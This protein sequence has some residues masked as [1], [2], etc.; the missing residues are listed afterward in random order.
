MVF[1]VVHFRMQEVVVG[2]DSDATVSNR[3]VY[4]VV[5]SVIKWRK[6][7]SGVPVPRN[8]MN[9]PIIWRGY[10][11]THMM[12]TL[13]GDKERKLR[14]RCPINHI[15]TKYPDSILCHCIAD[16]QLIAGCDS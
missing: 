6:S 5:Q 11:I 3:Q 1:I 12:F 10:R 14:F 4:L 8:P 7:T 16:R 2:G 15:S 13:A 9:F